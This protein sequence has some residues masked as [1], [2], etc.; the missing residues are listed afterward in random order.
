MGFSRQEYWSGLPFPFPGDLPDSGIEPGST[1]FQ[2]DTLTSEPP[3]KL[4]KR[5]LA[6]GQ[7]S[8]TATVYSSHEFREDFSRITVL[9]PHFFLLPTGIWLEF[10][11]VSRMDLL[12][13]PSF[14]SNVT[15]S[16]PGATLFCHSDLTSSNQDSWWRKHIWGWTKIWAGY[17]FW[18]HMK[19]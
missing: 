15:L 5:K 17:N 2:A 7:G 14:P 3:R 13:S 11:P 9:W 1:A 8:Q 4:R 18:I 6:W 16:L 19:P 10:T 12:L